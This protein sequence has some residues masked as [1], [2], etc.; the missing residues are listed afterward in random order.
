MRTR[1]NVSSRSTSPGG[2]SGP[3]ETLWHGPG[4]AKSGVS[5]QNRLVE[6]TPAAHGAYWKSYDFKPGRKRGKLT[7]F[8]LGPRNLFGNRPHPFDRQAFDHDGG[9]IIWHLPNGLQGYMLI[10]AEG[11][12]IDEGPIDVVSDALKTSGTPAIVNGLSCMACHKHGMIPF[13]DSIRDHSAVFGVAQRKV[14]ELYPPAAVMEPLVE[15]DREQFMDAL[16]QCIGPFLRVDGNEGIPIEEFPEPIAEVAR[17]HRLVFLD[18]ETVACELNI[19]DPQQLILRVGLKTLKELGLET[20]TQKDG[21][22]SRLDWEAFDG[23]SL[24]QDLANQLGFTPEIA[25]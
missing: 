21:V 14:Q 7:R 6:R 8:P 17:M 15:Q 23:T 2:S 12:R 25:L 3:Q 19:A 18:L 10:D 13:Q 1:W 24:M 5:G 16:E 22:I 20:L 11:T 9:E 4:F